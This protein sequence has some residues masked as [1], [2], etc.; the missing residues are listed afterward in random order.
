MKSKEILLL[1]FGI[2]AV[3]LLMDFAVNNIVKGIMGIVS[4]TALSDNLEREKIKLDNFCSNLDLKD[5]AYDC[6]KWIDYSQEYNITSLSNPIDVE[7]VWETP[8]QYHSTH[9]VEFGC[10]L[11]YLRLEY[12]EF[13]KVY[14]VNWCNGNTL[15]EAFDNCVERI[16]IE[17]RD[18]ITII[19]P[20]MVGDF[21]STEGV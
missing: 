16:P 19:E 10:T 4:V 9:N 6:S 17:F 7:C 21:S 20:K 5:W 15:K 13:E 11:G 2:V 8:T 14:D 1:A 12:P 18:K 3:I